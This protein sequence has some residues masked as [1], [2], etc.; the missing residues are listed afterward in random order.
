LDGPKISWDKLMPIRELDASFDTNG[1][2]ICMRSGLDVNADC[3]KTQANP[4]SFPV[5]GL[6]HYSANDK[7]G[8][9]NLSTRL[10]ILKL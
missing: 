9:S 4:Q 1:D 7:V 8:G 5:Y 3:L 10:I 2:S 6:T